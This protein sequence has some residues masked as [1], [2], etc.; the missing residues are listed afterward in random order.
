MSIPGKAL[1]AF[2]S[3]LAVSAIATA[4]LENHSMTALLAPTTAAALLA[5]LLS[6]RALPMPSALTGSNAGRVPSARASAEPP[7]GGAT[8]THSKPRQSAKAP[9]PAGRARNKRE[10]S[11]NNQPRGQ[12][13]AKSG[14]APVPGGVLEQ[15]TVKWF[16]ASKGFGF[17]VRDNGDEIFVH[18]RSI[19]GEGR[20]SL[21][22]G[23]PVR[24]RVATTDKGPQ[25][26][27]VQACD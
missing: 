5:V 22:D 1:I 10:Q 2:L 21:R 16:N 26:E 7:S 17:I 24:F 23:A 25:A 11:D 8:A 12:R 13:S 27:D 9:E 19:Q 14:P 18:H 6:H 20:R 3:A 15:G 4:L